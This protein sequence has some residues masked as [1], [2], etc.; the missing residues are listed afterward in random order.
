M[1]AELEKERLAALKNISNT[2]DDSEDPEA[3]RL[4]G[5]HEEGMNGEFHLIRK[6]IEALLTCI[7]LT[8]EFDLSVS[9][10]RCFCP[11]GEKMR[12]WR[13]LVK[14][15]FMDQDDG[16]GSKNKQGHF[17]NPDRLIAHLKEKSKGASTY[18]LHER[19]LQYLKIIYRDQFF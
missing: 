14:C 1:L 2:S 4:Q 13:E 10:Q 17:D 19:V 5:M 6:F 8:L 9:A 11:C 7:L 18:Q 16:C 3:E 12:K 15:E